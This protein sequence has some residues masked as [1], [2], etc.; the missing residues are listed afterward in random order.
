MAG[1][2]KLVHQTRQEVEAGSDSDALS[3]DDEDVRVA[4]LMEYV[5]SW[6]HAGEHIKEAI[7]NGAEVCLSSTD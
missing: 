1:A 7:S 3:D 4:T 2:V 6:T 5:D